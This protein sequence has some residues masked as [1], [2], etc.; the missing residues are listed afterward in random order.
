MELSV[1]KR[2]GPIDQRLSVA[3]MLDYTDRHCRFIHRLFSP[4]ARLYTE[5]VVAAAVVRGDARRLLE[6]DPAEHPVVLQ[7]G[8]SDPTELAAAARI[9]ASMGYDEINLNVGCPSD[10]VRDGA[11]GACLMREPRTVASCMAAM[12]DA[13]SV[14]VSVKCRIGL[15][16]DQRYESFAAF[17]DTVAGAGV[18]RF[19]VHARNAILSGLS[20]K[21]NREIPPLKYPFVYRLKRER[22]DLQVTLNGGLKDCESALMALRAGLNGV[23]LGRAAY[24][25]PALLAELQR[26]LIDPAWTVPSPLAILEA[27]VPYAREQLQR[28]VRLHAITR[29]LSGLLNGVSGARA[30]RRFLSQCAARPGAPAEILL[31]GA[32][33]LRRAA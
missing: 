25:R 17:I 16:S 2:S 31:A 18:R 1:E 22:P 32:D 8:G 12:A 26:A 15:D 28:G 29:H 3:P 30:W 21:Q 19:V 33:I 14:P 7:L 11:F 6:F 9:G 27:V 4:H 24:Q 13:V 23:M 20:P 10:R 5:M